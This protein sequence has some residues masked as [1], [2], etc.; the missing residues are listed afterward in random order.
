MLDIVIL[1][2]KVNEEWD[3]FVLSHP[4]GTIYHTSGWCQLI[5]QTYGHKPFYLLKKDGN[6]D[7]KA[8]LPFFIIGNIITRKHISSLPGAQFCNPLLSNANEFDGFISH[9]LEMIRQNGYKYFELKLNG[10][11]PIQNTG[12]WSIVNEY[13]IYTLDTS[14]PLDEIFSSFHKSCIQRSCPDT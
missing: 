3:K 4:L 14:R 2:D 9:I 12:S 5:R 13:F 10:N 1:N 11:F 7:I 8:G 6:G